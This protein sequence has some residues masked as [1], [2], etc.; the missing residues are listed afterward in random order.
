MG[1]SLDRTEGQRTISAA[2][3]DQLVEGTVVPGE[4]QDFR[5]GVYCRN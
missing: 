2:A 4:I 5:R 1:G 3:R